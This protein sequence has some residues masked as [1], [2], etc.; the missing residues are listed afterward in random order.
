MYYPKSQILENL[1]TN[2]SE[3]MIEATKKAYTGNYFRTSDG[4]IYTGKNPEDKPNYLLAPITQKQPNP[5]TLI[6]DNNA[7]Q[8]SASYKF[9][10]KQMGLEINRPA[11]PPIQII[12][13][14]TNNDYS[15]G[16]FMRYFLFDPVNKK[17][18]ETN[19]KTYNKF[20]GQVS[21]VQF[22]KFEPIKVP[23]ELIGNRAQVFRANKNTVMLIEKRNSYWGF[24]KFFK[25]KYTQYFS[26]SEN[27]NLYTGGNELRYKQSKKVYIGFYHIHP[28]KG[29]MVG[30]QHV[31]TPH[32]FLE[33]IPTGSRFNPLPITKQSGSYV[34]PTSSVEIT[35]GGPIAT[36][37]GGGGSTSYSGGG[38]AGGGGGY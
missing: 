5:L 17:T 22:K 7:V 37:G 27:E 29:P 20:V 21:S 35:L 16:S 15:N 30:A 10:Q 14:P 11:Q 9:Q 28:D 26:F 8:W 25:E 32:E 3:Y 2:G 4:T 33:Y 19:L 6:P 1:Y 12:P 13:Q 31:D 24:N 34:E 23:W 36:G 18:L 38:S